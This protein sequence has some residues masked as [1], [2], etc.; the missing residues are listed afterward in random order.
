MKISRFALALATFCLVGCA[1]HQ[2]GE[3]GSTQPSITS[4]GGNVIA[5]NQGYSLLY[6]LMSDEGNVNKIL[7]IKSVDDPVKQ[8]IKQISDTCSAARVQL[9]EYQN[10][11]GKSEFDVPDL[12]RIEQ[13]T[14]DLESNVDEKELLFSSGKDFQLKLILTQLQAT[15]Y[16]QLMCTALADIENIPQ[17]KD[18]LTKLAADLRGY[19]DTLASLIEAK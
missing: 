14:R 3:S 17:R 2:T 4:E 13:E 15:R 1:N 6:R 12:P 10:Q 9:D 19:H 16:G 18:F 7:I 8:V 5:R 11:D